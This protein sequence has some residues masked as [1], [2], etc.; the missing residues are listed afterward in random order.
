M[1][2][3]HATLTLRQ[4]IGVL[5]CIQNKAKPTLVG[6]YWPQRCLDDDFFFMWTEKVDC[7]LH[8]C[9]DICQSYLNFFGKEALFSIDKWFRDRKHPLWPAL[10]TARP[11]QQWIYS[12][13]NPSESGE[14]SSRICRKIVRCKRTCCAKTF[15]R[16]KVQRHPFWR[17]KV[18]SGSQ[19]RSW[20][21]KRT[22]RRVSSKQE[23]ILPVE[24]RTV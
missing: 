1:L 17:R 19:S 9:F 5:L 18:W 21:I 15:K 23:K 13:L 20:P 24:S 14:R 6:N 4:Y 2:L 11:N 7:Q 22:D 3:L 10:K 8:L 12:G 16:L